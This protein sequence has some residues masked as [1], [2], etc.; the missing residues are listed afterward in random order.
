MRNGFHAVVEAFGPS[1]F[2][3][4]RTSSQRLHTLHSSNNDFSN[5][6]PFDYKP[7]NSYSEVS[8][9]SLR[10]MRIKEVTNQLLNCV[11]DAQATQQILQENRELLLEPLENGVSDD[12][13]SIYRPDMTR[14]ER[15]QTYNTSM[16][17]RIEKA[18]NGQVRSVLEAMRDFILSNK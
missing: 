13:E 8:R 9:I 18:K 11:G 7:S 15:Y 1:S 17:E 2:G 16:E 4:R 5:F 3:A 6:N 14:Q 10:Q 12:P